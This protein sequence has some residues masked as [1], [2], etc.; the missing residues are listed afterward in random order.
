MSDLL[1]S[2]NKREGCANTPEFVIDYG[3]VDFRD[4]EITP[5][6]DGNAWYEAFNADYTIMDYRMLCEE[7]RNGNSHFGYPEAGYDAGWSSRVAV[8]NLVF[9]YNFVDVSRYAIE[10]DRLIDVVAEQYKGM[11]YMAVSRYS[12]DC[13]L[14]VAPYF[15][16]KH[17]SYAQSGDVDRLYVHSSNSDFAEVAHEFFL[18]AYLR[19]QSC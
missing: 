7:L 9:G 1:L 14:V 5:F 2:I 10:V 15:S 13:E 16:D 4:P 18:P 3:D 12:S 8:L 17:S 19:K 11:V 6:G